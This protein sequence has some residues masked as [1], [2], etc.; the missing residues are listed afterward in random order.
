MIRV[1]LVAWYHVSLGKRKKEVSKL[2]KEQGGNT[3]FLFILKKE[4]G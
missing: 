2:E 3:S 4:K 1:S